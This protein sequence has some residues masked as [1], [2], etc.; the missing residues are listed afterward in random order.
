MIPLT[1]LQREIMEEFFSIPKTCVLFNK[2]ER[3]TLWNAAL[4]R[5][6][7]EWDSLKRQCPALVHRVQKSYQSG[8]N[9][10]S[11]VFS[12]CVYA[13]TFANMF[14]LKKFVNC[15]ENPSFVPV[16]IHE[17]LTSY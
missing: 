6:E 7:M 13:Q 9:I 16:Q 1:K 11:A 12:E 2:R 8:D 3:K 5:N 10:Q 14:S 15:E 4:R 17:L